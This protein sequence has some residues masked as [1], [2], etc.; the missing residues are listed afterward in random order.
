MTHRRMAWTGYMLVL[1]G[2]TLMFSPKALARCPASEDTCPFSSPS[3]HILRIS[4]VSWTAS[5]VLSIG[6]SGGSLAACISDTVFFIY[7]AASNADPWNKASGLLADSFICLGSGTDNLHVVRAGAGATCAGAPFTSFNYNG[8]E[9][10]VRGQA[11]DDE[12]GGGDG[13]DDY[14]GGSGFDYG[15]AHA[16]V[17]L[18]D[19]GTG[20][21]SLTSSETTPLTTVVYGGPGNDFIFGNT[22]S[23]TLLYGEDD[24]D[25]VLGNA[26][27]PVGDC[28]AP[29][30][31]DRTNLSSSVTGCETFINPATCLDGLSCCGSPCDTDKHPC[32][33]GGACGANGFCF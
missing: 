9:L 21:D 1:G 15:S 20:G 13:D 3:R 10:I 32:P 27:W 11:G 14:C 29:S 4:G 5:N 6:R 26:Y 18:L 12:F 25:C 23:S 30:S 8:Y 33:G 31:G 2:L 19:G 22:G 7:P 24:T 17:N 28:G 16:G